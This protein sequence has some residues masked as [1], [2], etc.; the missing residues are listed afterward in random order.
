LPLIRLEHESEFLWGEEQRRAFGR[1]KRYLASPPVL[2]APRAGV[3]FMMY[4]VAQEHVIGATLTQEVQG[5]E[6]VVAYMSRRL[7]D[8]ETRYTFIEKLSL[9]LYYSCTKLRH[10]LLTSSCT[11]VCQYDVIKCML[12]KPILSGRLGKWA[13]ALVEY[14]L[15]YESLKASKGQVVADFIVEHMIDIEQDVC[16]VEEGTWK[17][18]FDGSVCVQGQGVGCFIESPHGVEQEV[19]LRLEFE[20]TNNQAEYKAL[21]SGL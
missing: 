3:E 18:Y 16:T 5:K 8:A 12:Q 6:F 20:C 13:Y 4:V 1:I 15:K 19:A 11:I 21:L 2:Q 7:V 9:F 10:Y 17:L 14:D